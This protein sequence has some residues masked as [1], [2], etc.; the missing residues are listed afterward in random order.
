MND[1]SDLACVDQV[2]NGDIDAFS[3]LVDK[4]RRETYTLALRIV[5][6]EEDAEEVS[7]D[8]FV[9]AFKSIAKFKREAAFST[10]LYRI[11]YNTALSK[12]KK[13]QLDSTSIEE[14]HEEI[15][16]SDTIQSFQQLVK[17]DQRKYIHH[18]LNRLSEEEATLINLHYIN[19]KA[20]EEVG[21][22]TG[23][24]HSNVRV[25]IFRARKKLHVYLH[26]AL[27]EEIRDIL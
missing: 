17:K 2:V 19:G 12:I 4:Y 5:K 25:K 7:Q 20:M 14:R 11:V 24:S 18:A 26:N 13:K 27:K 9:K 10:W 21:K 8:A 16:A 15:S 3:T 22:I 1:Q 23:L 6:N